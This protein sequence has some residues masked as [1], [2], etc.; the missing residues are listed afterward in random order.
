MGSLTDKVAIVRGGSGGI[1][2]TIC[3]RLAQEGAVVVHYGGHASSANK[4]VNKIKT[5]GGQAGGGYV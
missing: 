2:S 3:E 1:G 5:N 4:I